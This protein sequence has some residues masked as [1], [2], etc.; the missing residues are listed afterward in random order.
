MDLGTLINKISRP[1][2]LEVRRA[3]PGLPPPPMLHYQLQ[4][5]LYFQRVLDMVRNV[6]GAVV[7]CG[8]GW[9]HSLFYLGCL[10]K[11]EMKGRRIW[12][13]DSFEGFP[14]PSPQDDSPR[15]PRKGEWSD[16]S[17]EGVRQMLVSS[18]LDAAFVE[19]QIRF[20]KG[21][22]NE[23]LVKYDG[24]PI[25]FLHLDVD[26]Y[27]SYLTTLRAMFPK[28]A[29]GG[30]VLFDEYLGAKEREKFPGAQRAIEE[31]FGARAAHIQRDAVTGKYFMIKR[32]P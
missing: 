32:E 30:A 10:V 6:E 14:E 20:V 28:V 24:G 15:K 19:S 2:G 21:F 31:Y 4:R 5:L 27:E 29:P 25:A 23:S 7:E 18:G 16:T 9:G 1:L 3:R 11:D 22:F 17:V 12:A 26:L 8:V 13:F